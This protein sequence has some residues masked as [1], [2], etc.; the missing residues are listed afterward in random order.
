MKTTLFCYIIVTKPPKNSQENVPQVRFGAPV[1][2]S[3]I[4][5]FS[6]I[7]LVTSIS[8]LVRLSKL[9]RTNNLL[10]GFFPHRLS[11][12]ANGWRLDPVQLLSFTQ[13]F[14]R[15]SPKSGF[16]QYYLF[17]IALLAFPF[18]H[19]PIAR[20]SS[21]P[22]A[23]VMSW[24]EMCDKVGKFRSYRFSPIP[25]FHKLIFTDIS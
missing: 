20:W 18:L 10:R 16:S 1:E 4:F 2:T 22:F 11:R 3:C 25:D 15:M 8:L 17:D 7:I 5:H 14:K 19:A 24:V 23:L 13:N 21:C 12:R 6:I 9:G